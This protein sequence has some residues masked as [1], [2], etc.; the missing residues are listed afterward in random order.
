VHKVRAVYAGTRRPYFRRPH[1]YWRR[2][3]T[4]I[5]TR[6]NG[7]DS[8]GAYFGRLVPECCMESTHSRAQTSPRPVQREASCRRAF[9]G[10]GRPRSTP[11][12]PTAPQSQDGN[13]G[14]RDDDH[15]AS[16]K[17]QY[18]VSHVCSSHW[19]VRMR[20]ITSSTRTGGVRKFIVPSSP[21]RRGRSEKTRAPGEYPTPAR[22]LPTH[23][24]PCLAVEPRQPFTTFEVCPGG[25]S[26]CAWTRCR[27]DGGTAPDYHF[28]RRAVC[29]SV[30]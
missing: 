4:P 17:S 27:G 19:P 1:G 7:G 16:A 14:S 23:A 26:S 28:G 9:G 25:T 5:K 12:R 20:R 2:K 30:F 6:V 11:R 24:L 8:E 22:Q 21:K 10:F 29:A 15:L 13:R 3:S 18:N